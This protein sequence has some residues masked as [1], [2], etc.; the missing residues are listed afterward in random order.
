MG[1]SDTDYL[2]VEQLYE[3]LYLFMGI[4]VGVDGDE[5][6]LEVKEFGFVGLFEAGDCLAEFG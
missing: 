3:L 1:A 6:G 2:G 5:D 4:A